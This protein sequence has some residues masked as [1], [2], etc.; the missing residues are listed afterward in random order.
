MTTRHLYSWKGP[1]RIESASV[2]T[3][4]AEPSCVAQHFE[5]YILVRCCKPVC[6]NTKLKEPKEFRLLRLKPRS[7]SNAT[8]NDLQVVCCT[9]EHS[10]RGRTPYIALSYTWGSPEDRST[11]E[12]GDETVSIGANLQSALQE[13]RSES[14]DVLLWCD[15]LCIN[16]EDDEE[17]SYEVQ[18]MK[19]IYQTAKRVVAWLG[20][21]AD[22][23]DKVLN[24]LRTMGKDEVAEDYCHLLAEHKEDQT[25]Y[26]IADAFR[27]FCQ[28][29]YWSRLWIMQ[30]VAVARNVIFVCGS[31]RIEYEDLSQ[32]VYFIEQAHFRLWED[33]ESALQKELSV[34]AQT[35]TCPEFS[36]V[37]GVLTRRDYTKN[38]ELQ[39]DN[40]FLQVLTMSLALEVD[41][42]TLNVRILAIGSSLC[43]VLPTMRPSSKKLSITLSQAKPSTKRRLG[44]FSS[45][46]MSTSLLPV[47]S[48]RH[49]RWHL[50]RLIGD[51]KYGDHAPV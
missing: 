45:K 42:T 20:P 31:S 11:I 48:P 27:S 37:K 14:H 32:A 15:Q 28:R 38:R 22:D 18:Q 44:S 35:F 13:L 25:L 34:L 24:T 36:F 10:I 46:A 3:S 5:V 26:P 12:V 19:D 6:F 30:E 33:E 4:G 17:R 7:R 2:S 50:G 21:A 16:Q 40:Y 29:T 43:W 51:S 39:D 9:I 41:Y 49:L 47:S 8:P 23:S 1:C